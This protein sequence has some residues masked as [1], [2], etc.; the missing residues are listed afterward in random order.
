MAVFTNT[1]ND[2]KGPQSKPN[3]V[4]V[5]SNQGALGSYDREFLEA[6]YTILA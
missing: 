1:T 4:R 3:D 6:N 5:K 2:R